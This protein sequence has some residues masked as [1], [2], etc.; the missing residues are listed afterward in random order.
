MTIKII[1]KLINLFNKIKILF[2]SSPVVLNFFFTEQTLKR[3]N[4]NLRTHFG[5]AYLEYYQFY[6]VTFQ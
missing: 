3:N 1:Q 4:I 5:F 2:H 6:G